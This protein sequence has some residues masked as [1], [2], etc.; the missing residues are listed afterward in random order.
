TEAR[1][2]PN[3]GASPSGPPQGTPPSLDDVFRRIVARQPH[4]P[5]LIDP[6]D[7]RRVTGEAPTGLTFAEAN[8][9]VTALAA[10]FVRSG[11]PAG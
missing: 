10:Q 7:K 4:V 5:A 6:P 9:A 1:R 8:R 11:L 2:S 3:T